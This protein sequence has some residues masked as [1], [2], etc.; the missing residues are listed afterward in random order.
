MGKKNAERGRESQWGE[1]GI[2]G[3]WRK[4]RGGPCI[5]LPNQAGAKPR[6]ANT[7][8]EITKLKKFNIFNKIV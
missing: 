4:Q 2:Y 6:E 8:T 3:R 7:T 5:A 1:G